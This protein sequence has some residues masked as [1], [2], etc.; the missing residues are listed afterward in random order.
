[1]FGIGGFE[2]LILAVFV[3]MI[4][5]PEKL[6]EIGRT[7]GRAM[8]MFNDARSDV[9]RVVRTE[10]LRPEDMETFQVLSGKR[11]YTSQTI[12][13]PSAT[14]AQPPKS[15]LAEL[16]EQRAREAERIEA[17]REAAQ[18]AKA[19]AQAELAAAE[20]ELKAAEA[21]A[22]AEAVAASGE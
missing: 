22:A 12:G 20:A 14:P 4:F 10:I 21:Q 1:M 9:E 18:A 19:A 17:E 6:P 7:F 13:S 11:K 5:G 15:A 16:E 3:L 2:L 8:R